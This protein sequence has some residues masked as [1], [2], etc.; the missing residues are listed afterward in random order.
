MAYD[1]KFR[2]HAVAFK[3][4]GHTFKRLKEVFG[5][6]S[7]TYYEPFNNRRTQPLEATENYQK[8]RRLHI[9]KNPKRTGL[10]T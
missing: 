7:A 3:D 10:N 8:K 1:E 4:G 6:C 5:I 9:R 2:A